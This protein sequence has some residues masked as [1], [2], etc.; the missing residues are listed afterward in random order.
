MPNKKPGVFI[1]YSHQDQSFIAPVVQLIQG[2]RKDYVFQDYTGLKTGAKWEPQLLQA[3][4]EAKLVIIFWCAHSAGS[5]WVKKE[6]QL[7]IK[8]NKEIMPV[9]LDESKLPPGL[10]LYQAINMSHLVSHN[11]SPKSI[12]RP[13]P[14]EGDF[15]MAEDEGETE[16]GSRSYS[17]PPKSF[18]RNDQQTLARHVAEA[19]GKHLPGK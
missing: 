1:S 17:A 13:I 14:V 8:G 10:S 9:I 15:D 18:E 3:L 5:K 16:R 19:M 11:V 7:A 6:Y 4:A 12:I 2:L